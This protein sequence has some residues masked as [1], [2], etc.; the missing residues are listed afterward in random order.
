MK[1]PY[2]AHS[3]TMFTRQTLTGLC[4]LAALTL[5]AC[6]ETAPGTE[7]G[8]GDITT[9]LLSDA[10]TGDVAADSLADGVVPD[11]PIGDSEPS[12][13]LSDGSDPD[14][15]QDVPVDVG[16]E[17]GEFGWACEENNECKSGYCIE[18]Y[19][20]K[21]CST[22]C[23]GAA[24]PNGFSCEQDL[25]VFPDVIFVCV[26]AFPR[27][28]YPCNTD[29]DCRTESGDSHSC[30]PTGDETK[31]SFCGGSCAGTACPSGYVC[32]VSADINGGQSQQCIPAPLAN[33]EAAE[34]TCSPGAV[35]SGASTNCSLTLE[36]IG[37]CGGERSCG[38]EGLTDCDAPTPALDACDG[39]DNDCDGIVDN[40]ASIACQTTNDFGTCDGTTVCD[41][42]GAI[43]CDAQVPSAESCDAV[44]N[45]C[46][47]TVD[48]ADAAGCTD[49]HVDGDGDG[50]GVGDP[51]C[52]CAPSATHTATADGDCDDTSALIK[53]NGLEVCNG[54]DDNCDG[55]IDEE[56]AT[57]C[58]LWN[59]DGDED[60]FGHPTDT[61]CYCGPTGFYTSKS[62]T[63]CDD[64]SAA[65][66]PGAAEIC[67]TIDNDCDGGTD[68][69][70]AG[71]CT[72][73][74]EDGDNDSFGDQGSFACLCAAEAPYVVTQGGDCDDAET[75]VNPNADELCDGIDND[76]DSQIDE[77]GAA[78]CTNYYRDGDSDDY[79]VTADFQCLCGPSGVYKTTASGDCNDGTTAVGPAATESCNGIDDNCDGTVDEEGAQGCFDYY[80]DVD[81]DGYG[82]GEAMCL[83]GATGDVTAL[84]DG[85]CNDNNTEQSPG[86]PELCTAVPVDENCDGNTDE[87]N[88]LAC[89]AFFVD[90]DGDSYGDP[91]TETCLCAP[92][93]NV[94]DGGDCDDT[95]GSGAAI[96]PGATETCNAAD[97]N[98][99]GIYD[100]G[101]G[102]ATTGW[103]THKYDNRRTGHRKD[104]QGPDTNTLKWKRTLPVTDRDVE[105]TPL[106]LA[107]GNIL[108]AHNNKVY[109]LN[110]ADGTTIWET[111]LATSFTNTAQ[112]AVQ[113][114]PTV[115]EGGT[116]YVPT[117]NGMSLL[118]PDGTILWYT[119]IGPDPGD[120]VRGTPSVDADGN[121]YFISNK[122]FTRMNP[123]GDIDWQI[124]IPNVQ[125]TPGHAAWNLDGT[126][127]YFTATNHVTYAVEPS[128]IVAWTFIDTGADIDGSC[129]VGKDGTI[130]SSMG[131]SVYKIQDTG[132]SPLELGVR[133]IGT[134]IDSCTS[135]YD[136]GI[137]EYAWVSPNGDNGVYKIPAATMADDGLYPM[138][139]SGSL[140]S[141]PVFDTDG[142]IY[143]GSDNSLFH[144]ARQDK[145]Q[146]W[147]FTMDN[148]QSD[149]SAA[150][151]DGFVVFADDEGV[152][153]LI[154]D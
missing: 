50:F 1:T 90:A 106:I 135:I 5:G 24:C 65:A 142:D 144:A 48:D 13:V 21:A 133:V 42:N 118:G 112:S 66:N 136:D 137:N 18:G 94:P 30:I 149:A 75:A 108:Y 124:A 84:V 145:T 127:M 76:C 22:V 100:E 16:P 72:I 2:T 105:V 15:A 29:E 46:N 80:L 141:A 10:V 125:Y 31:G 107:D 134:D 93:G 54:V 102:L 128:G 148:V 58:S 154:E 152:V 3:T 43:V 123:A 33:G 12:E 126:R 71:N 32:A 96:S 38:A 17:P 95:P 83:C 92:A 11:A 121:A 26:P 57:G 151:G 150:V 79:G 98:C 109:K 70:G 20:G 47:G 14:I 116:I 53:P 146:K 74:Y 69:A 19:A 40:G 55:T 101:C 34:C 28:C 111:E 86:L 99:N 132:P 41:V 153:Y 68:E 139:K 44:D 119:S 81:D 82:T 56:N 52:L 78:D 62:N 117:G 49:Y 64:S 131:G 59:L 73:Y 45:D 104:V 63:D 114:G 6:P 25:A 51:Q 87:P 122:F 9:D 77:A 37:S 130:Y 88:A 120:A 27:L 8:S 138:V 113:A 61:K 147:T 85:D 60:T 7:D 115:R 140:N 36:D 4:V 110:Y 103:P 143:I 39:E 89:T 91:A 97:D 67:D 129:T 23:S 35:A